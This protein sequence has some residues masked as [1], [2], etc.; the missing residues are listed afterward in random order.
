MDS[1]AKR[2]DGQKEKAKRQLRLLKICPD[3]APLPVDDALPSPSGPKSQFGKEL[4][5]F[6]DDLDA[7][8]QRI[9]NS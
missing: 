8:I 9:L 4:T 6:A 3:Q 5:R 1:A 7:E 2:K